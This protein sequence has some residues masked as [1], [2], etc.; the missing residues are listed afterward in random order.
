MST[1]TD[2]IRHGVDTQKLTIRVTAKTSSPPERVL[3]AG[4]DFSKRRADVWPNVKENTSKYT[5][6]GRP[7]LTSRRAPGSSACSGSGTV[8]TGRNWDWSRRR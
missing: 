8:T 5:S 7:S 4:R 6:S 2:A 1:V 3:D